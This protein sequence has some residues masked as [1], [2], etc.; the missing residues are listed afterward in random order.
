MKIQKIMKINNKLKMKII[1]M[2]NKNVQKLKDYLK[3]I[4]KQK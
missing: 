3:I 2:I 1:K 4:Y